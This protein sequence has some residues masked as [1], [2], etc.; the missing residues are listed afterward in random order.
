MK[1]VWIS[2]WYS[3]HYSICAER[4]RGAG[5]RE[6]KL[7]IS[8]QG[9]PRWLQFKLFGQDLAVHFLDALDGLKR[10]RERAGEFI[11]FLIKCLMLK[12]IISPATSAWKRHLWALGENPVD[13]ILINPTHRIKTAVWK[14]QM[15]ACDPL[16]LTARQ[17]RAS[18]WSTFTWAMPSYCSN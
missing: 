2:T 16:S 13:S 10:E 1:A 15:L 14:A 5:E 12:G 4:R 3:C 18:S 6:T 11:S 9:D 8:F 17:G 7:V